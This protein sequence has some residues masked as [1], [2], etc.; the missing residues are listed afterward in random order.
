MPEQDGPGASLGQRPVTRTASRIAAG[1]QVMGVSFA[2]DGWL[3]CSA[4]A[5]RTIRVWDPAAAAAARRGGGGADACLAIIEP[6]HSLSVRAV[7]AH[8]A[9]TLSSRGGIFVLNRSGRFGS[10]GSAS[11]SVPQPRLVPPFI[12]LCQS[13]VSK[14]G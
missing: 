10:M 12:P 13:M 3:L 2:S 9:R 11:I 6:A 8:P 14:F 1:G 5:D 7:W 4:S